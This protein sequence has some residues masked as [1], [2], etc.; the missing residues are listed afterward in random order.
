M[1]A[2]AEI[3]ERPG[4][5]KLSAEV[6][7]P[8]GV[9]EQYAP[10][11]RDIVAGTGARHIVGCTT[12]W[13]RKEVIPVLEKSGTLLW[14]P[15]PYEGFECNEQV[16]YLGACPNQHVLRLFRIRT[17]ALRHQRLPGRLQLYLGLGNLAYCP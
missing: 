4:G 5:L 8:Q 17:A 13:S 6:R 11:A 9:T 3:N 12:S 2:I 10:L 7:D 15:C 14:Y 16:M 1:T